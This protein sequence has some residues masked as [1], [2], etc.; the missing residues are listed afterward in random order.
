MKT[1]IRHSEDGTAILECIPLLF[2]FVLFIGYSFGSFGVIHTSILNSIA[3][4]NYAFETFRHRTNLIYQRDTKNPVSLYYYGSHNRVHLIQSE[5]NDNSPSAFYATERSLAMGIP[6][7]RPL[8][9]TDSIYHATKV[10]EI[11]TGVQNQDKEVSPVWV[12]TQYGICLDI[13]CGD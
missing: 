3:A 12:M 4:R 2:V 10:Y 1:D 7:A 6:S 9:R 5:S 8:H 13:N 11:V